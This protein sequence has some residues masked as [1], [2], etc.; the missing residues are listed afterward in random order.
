LGQSIALAKKSFRTKLAR[1][2]K[3]IETELAHAVLNSA[4]VRF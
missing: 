2:K 3:R 4:H 1:F